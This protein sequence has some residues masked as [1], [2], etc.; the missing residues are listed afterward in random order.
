[1]L[2][3]VFIL[4]AG[5]ATLNSLRLF[6]FSAPMRP[7]F[8]SNTILRMSN[9]V[10]TYNPVELFDPTTKKKAKILIKNG[11]PDIIEEIKS[12]ESSK[13]VKIQKIDKWVQEGSAFWLNE[14]GTRALYKVETKD[15]EPKAVKI[16]KNLKYSADIFV[17]T[18]S[19]KSESL[20]LIS[21]S[22]ISS[23][24]DIQL[25]KSDLRVLERQGQAFSNI[26]MLITDRSI[27]NKANTIATRLVS[28]FPIQSP[29]WKTWIHKTDNYNAVS[30]GQAFVHYYNE[31]SAGDVGG[32]SAN[33]IPKAGYPGTLAPGEMFKTTNPVESLPN[34]ILHPWPAMQEFQFHVRY[35]PNH[36]MIPPPVLWFAQNDMYTKNYTSFQLNMSVNEIIGGMG[37][38]PK[39]AIRIAQNARIG[40]SY[41]PEEQID[42]GGSIFA[43]G[44]PMANY[45]ADHG[46]TVDDADA[47]PPIPEE[48]LPYTER[49]LDPSYGL[50]VRNAVSPES[51]INAEEEEKEEKERLRAIEAAFNMAEYETSLYEEEETEKIWLDRSLDQ[52]KSGRARSPT[53]IIRYTIATIKEL[54]EEITKVERA[55]SSRRKTGRGKK[56]RQDF[57]LEGP[58]PFDTSPTFD[59]PSKKASIRRASS[60]TSIDYD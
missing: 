11:N 30:L 21:A 38:E 23:L 47:A 51:H 9:L 60:D 18:A 57:D 14:E 25:N 4:L 44:F 20:Q 24:A 54:K 12:W 37:M 34:R 6:R 41:I 53:S 19:E 16:P 59:S 2:P 58:I 39:H 8:R 43:G 32:V 56:R 10:T 50:K 46:P 49:W 40:M 17:N 3:S 48:L 22:C 7:R 45:N 36:P 42:H 13:T 26:S 35:P 1:M 5:V 28:D 27:T 29:Q 31:H 52:A 33:Y 55:M 15:N